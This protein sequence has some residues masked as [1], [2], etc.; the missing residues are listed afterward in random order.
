MGVRK[1]TSVAGKW[2]GCLLVL[3]FSG[4]LHAGKVTYVYTDPQGTPLAEA[5]ANGTII[6]TYDYAPYG[7]PVAGMSG[8]PDG[9]GYTG[10]VN[11]P[12]TGLVYMQARYYDPGVGRF[13]SVDP[14]GPS[15]GN[16]SSF[17]RYP[18]ANNNPIVNSD[19]DGRESPCIESPNGCSNASP[20]T[21]AL[22][23]G[24]KQFGVGAEK[25]ILNALPRDAGQE[26][27]GPSNSTQAAGMVAGDV[28]IGV[29]ITVASDGDGAEAGAEAL[30]SDLSALDKT[31]YRLGKS[32]ESASRLGRKSAEAESVFGHG[33]SVTTTKPAAGNVCSSASCANL[34]SRGFEVKSSPTRNDPNHHTVI[35]PKPVTK[36]V[37]KSFNDAFGR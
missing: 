33:V 34:Q 30:V 17:S 9:P 3:L 2:F 19:P 27:L 29:A 26:D 21:R 28:A 20:A 32:P 14:V 1:G 15:P 35:L 5:D 4:I 16:V 24:I 11:D 23:E 25:K 6:A 13:L 8:S 7:Q 31:V 37:A 22:A 10:H 36:D 12:E 18:Y